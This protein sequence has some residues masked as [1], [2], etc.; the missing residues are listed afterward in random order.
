MILNFTLLYIITQCE[1]GKTLLKGANKGKISKIYKYL[2]LVTVFYSNV[3][4]FFFLNLTLPLTPSHLYRFIDLTKICNLQTIIIILPERCMAATLCIVQLK[5]TI[6]LVI[7]ITIQQVF[8]AL[9][10][11]QH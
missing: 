6:T 7:I 3:L 1:S 5:R 2:S 8:L 10:Q 11:I 4:N 9:I